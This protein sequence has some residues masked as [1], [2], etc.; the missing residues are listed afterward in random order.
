MKVKLL[1]RLTLS[2]PVDCSTPGSSIHGFFPGKSTGVGFLEME[3]N[4]GEDAVKIVEMTAKGLKYYTNLVEKVTTGFVRIESN[5]ER[6]S[7][8]GKM[9]SNST[10][11]Y[12]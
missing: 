6:S 9:V 7:T 11:C 3:S 2:N 12:S 5:F 8:V 1:S 10:A 4:S